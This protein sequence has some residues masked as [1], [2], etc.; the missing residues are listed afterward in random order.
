MGCGFNLRWL[1]YPNPTCLLIIELT[2]V[3]K[4]TANP[5]CICLSIP[6]IYTQA[7]AAQICDTF[8]DTQYTHS[9]RTFYSQGRIFSCLRQ[10]SLSNYPTGFLLTSLSW[11]PTAALIKTRGMVP[12]SVSTRIIS[13]GLQSP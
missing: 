8:W 1:T 5:Y 10:T 9:I 6:Q 7:D 2:I 13:K 12:L 4:F 3:P 11:V